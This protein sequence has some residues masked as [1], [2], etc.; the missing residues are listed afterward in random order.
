MKIPTGE[1]M[2]SLWVR[3]VATAIGQ[4]ILDHAIR[5]DGAPHKPAVKQLAAIWGDELGNAIKAAG[6]LPAENIASLFQ[7]GTNEV[8][9]SLS[10]TIDPCTGP[11]TS[12]AFWLVP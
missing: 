3:E 12:T 1:P 8:T 4:D 7:A 6:P 5:L 11:L 10:W 9:I 2:R